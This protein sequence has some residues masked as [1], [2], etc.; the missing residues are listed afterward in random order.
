MIKPLVF[1]F[2]KDSNFYIYDI[3]TNMIIRVSKNIYEDNSFDSYIYQ[4]YR[5]K[6]K[7]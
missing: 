2:K 6:Y 5:K 1:K 3:N 4:E 7:L